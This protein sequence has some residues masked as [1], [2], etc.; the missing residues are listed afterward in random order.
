[1]ATARASPPSSS[2]SASTRSIRRAATTTRAPAAA[3]SRAKWA[4]SPEEAPVIRQV[5]PV[6]FPIACLVLLVDPDPRAFDVEG[7]GL[8]HRAGGGAAA[9]LGHHAGDVVRLD[10]VDGEVVGRGLTHRDLR[11]RIEAAPRLD[12]GN[13]ADVV[14][15]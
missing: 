5:R 13:R 6:S 11:H 12:A 4:P 2:T 9:H 10:L 1:M 7:V 15:V 3:A 8:H 14:D